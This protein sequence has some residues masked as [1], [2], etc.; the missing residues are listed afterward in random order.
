MISF[1]F[2]TLA[3]AV[4]ALAACNSTLPALPGGAGGSPGIEVSGL[5]L[6]SPFFS[7]HALDATDHLVTVTTLFDTTAHGGGMVTSA[8]WGDVM[9]VCAPL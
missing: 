3:V 9:I 2:F 6:P 8:G 5:Y 1:K 7:H 4:L